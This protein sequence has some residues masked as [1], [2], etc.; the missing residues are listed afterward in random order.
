[1][2]LKCQKHECRW[3]RR[4]EAR[5]EE[6][7]EAALELFAEK[8]F[9]SVRMTDVAKQAGISKG[10]LYLYFD[11]KEAIFLE[12]VKTVITPMVDEA[13]NGI[14]QFEGTATELLQQFVQRWWSKVWYSHLSAIPKLVFS[15]A[16]NFPEI[17]Q[18]YTEN[19]VKRF[20]GLFENIIQQG[21][22][23]NEFRD[24]DVRTASRLLMAPVIQANIWKHALAPYDSELDPETYIQLHLEIFLSGLKKEKHS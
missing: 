20:R 9:S 22:T 23:N 5:P 18:Y 15:E 6:I 7:L 19:V 11:S 12:L 2:I 21:I 14:K 13:E 24:C 17:G 3:R 16:G 10:T 1:M 4:K 8:G